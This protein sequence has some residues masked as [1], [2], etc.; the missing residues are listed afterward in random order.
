M[1][2]ILSSVLRPCPLKYMCS[3]LWW[4]QYVKDD[5]PNL[6]VL[7]FGTWFFYPLKDIL[8]MVKCF[9]IAV[10]FWFDNSFYYLLI[11]GDVDI[12]D[13]YLCDEYWEFLDEPKL[14]LSCQYLRP[15]S[16]QVFWVLTLL[17]L[18]HSKKNCFVKAV[19]IFHYWSVIDMKKYVNILKRTCR[20]RFFI[21]CE[22]YFGITIFYEL[23]KQFFQVNMLCHADSSI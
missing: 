20:I 5:S 16:M 4:L 23:L 19:Y 17:F 14:F 3:K 22:G 15:F 6:N 2:E 10:Y 11:C 9:S 18:R 7:N 12:L 21:R 8:Q 1:W 13:V